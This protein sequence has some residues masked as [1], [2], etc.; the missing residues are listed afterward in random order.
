MKRLVVFITMFI[1]SNQAFAFTSCDE[2]KAKIAKNIEAKG[3]TSY[4]LDVVAVSEL[5]QKKVAGSCEGGTKKIVYS[6]K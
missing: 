2:L 6:K 3:I 4:S 5:R 1:V